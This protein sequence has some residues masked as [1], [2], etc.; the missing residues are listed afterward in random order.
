MR[1]SE[2]FRPHTPRPG[3]NIGLRQFSNIERHDPRRQP[4]AQKF[5]MTT[6]GVALAGEPVR[7]TPSL[8]HEIVCAP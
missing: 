1:S 6:H 2:P 5:A 3:V 8:L 4:F 7:R